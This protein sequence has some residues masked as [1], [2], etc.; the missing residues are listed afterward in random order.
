MQPLNP[1]ASYSHHIFSPA[2]LYPNNLKLPALYYKN[3][4]DLKDNP[5]EDVKALFASNGWVNAWTDGIFTYHHFHSK[6]HE[7][8]AVI[9]GDCMIQLGG[10]NGN[11]QKITKGDVLILP[12]GVVHKN[13]GAS[14]DFLVVG[15]YPDGQE[16]D[17]NGCT[18]TTVDIIAWTKENSHQVAL[19]VK[20]PVFGESGPVVTLWKNEDAEHVLEKEKQF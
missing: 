15:A 8:L 2:T 9:S 6:A 3:V 17:L 7:V 4:L 5:E 12:V 18:E 16:V 14:D 19:P 20:D 11:I 1:S 13:V 10:D